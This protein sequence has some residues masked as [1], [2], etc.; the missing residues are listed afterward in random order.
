MQ[1]YFTDSMGQR[2][3]VAKDIKTPEEAIKYV[4]E[5]QKRRFVATSGVTQLKVISDTVSNF[6]AAD[7]KNSGYSLE[8]V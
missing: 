1:I 2:N 7:G 4:L 6:C 8:T 3:L 5:H